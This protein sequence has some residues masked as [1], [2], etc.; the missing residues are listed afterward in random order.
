[1]YVATGEFDLLLGE[2]S[3]L[4][5]KRSL[6]RPI[7]AHLQR[8]FPVA[9]AEV[10]EAALLRRCVIGVAAVSNDPTAARATVEACERHLAQR[11]ECELLAAAVRV[12]QPTGDFPRG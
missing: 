6:V 2:V 11:P 10:G 7:V 3:S 8:H 12:F 5:V 9:C 1:M 4:K